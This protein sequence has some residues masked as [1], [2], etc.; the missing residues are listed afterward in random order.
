[1][2]LIL[3]HDQEPALRA[4]Q[5]PIPE[6]FSPAEACSDAGDVHRPLYVLLYGRFANIKQ[7]TLGRLCSI[8]MNHI[9]CMY[10]YIYICVCECWGQSQTNIRI[11]EAKSFTLKPKDATTQSSI[12]ILPRPWDP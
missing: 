2:H 11:F 7:K 8:H 10:I 9:L 6:D 12:G 1:M 3:F 5:I 4:A